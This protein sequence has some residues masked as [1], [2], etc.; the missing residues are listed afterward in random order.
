MSGD[1]HFRA[2][3]SSAE[4]IAKDAGDVLTEGQCL[5][6]KGLG[7]PFDHAK[8]VAAYE[9][10]MAG[11]SP[12]IAGATAVALACGGTDPERDRWLEMAEKNV[13][14]GGNSSLSAA[15]ELAR[16]DN[17]M[18]RGRLR[19]AL[20]AAMYAAAGGHVMPLNRLRGIGQILQLAVLSHELDV[21]DLVSE[22]SDDLAGGWPLGSDWQKSTWTALAGLLRLWSA[23]KRGGVPPVFDDADLGRMNRNAVTPSVVRMVCRAAIDRGEKPDALTA[24][25][26]EGP[27][28]P[29]S[30][31]DLSIKAVEAAAA[32]DRRDD[33]RARDLWSAV[34]ARAAPE[35]YVL[36]ACDAL[37]AMGFV[38]VRLGHLS[39][40]AQML[41]A[42]RGRRGESGYSHRFGFEQR[43]VDEAFA[44]LGLHGDIPAAPWAEA[45]Q[46]AL[47]W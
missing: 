9:L 42:A 1:E 7:A 40:A 6:V 2:R 36:L 24:A 25:H 5:F 28:A 39:Q 43:Q 12:V 23:L 4:V 30:L 46:L 14:T 31:M 15:Y 47:S 26:G 8:L 38:A 22:L 35:R 33:I 10:S 16:A 13:N 45:V 18:E 29:G 11:S 41:R 20:T 34:L 3:L 19:E 27:P 21:E 37:E 44:A 17:L 32:A